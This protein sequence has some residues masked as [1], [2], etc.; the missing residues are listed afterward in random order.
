[1]KLRLYVF[2]AVCCFLIPDHAWAQCAGQIM[3]PGFQFLSSSKGC[4]PF[5]FQIQTKYFQS[6]PGTV[7][8]VDFGDG[9]PEQIY[10]QTTPGPDGPVISHIYPNSPQNC[11]YEL[12]IE[13]ENTCN[14]RGSTPLEP[15]FVTVWT[16]DVLDINPQEFRVCQGYAATVQFTDN[17]TWNCFPHPNANRENDEARWIQWIYGTGAAAT[18]IPGVQINSIAPGA[19]PY[20]DPAPNRNPRYPV[21]APGEVTLPITVPVTA[22]ADIGKEFEVT[23]KNWNQCNPYDATPADGS[24][25]PV[26]LINGDNPAEIATARIVIVDA[27]QPNF[28]AR[29]GN[30][31]G[32]VQTVFCVGDAIFF[33]NETPAIAGAAFAYTWEFFD[34]N[35][36]AGAPIATRTTTNPTFTYTSGGQKLIRLRV[37]D[38]NAA[39]NCEAIF[40][41]VITIS[42]SLIA[43]ISVTDLSG[44]TITPDF[45]QENSAPFTTFNAR[46]NDASTGVATPSTEWRWEFY[47]EA[48]ALIFEAPASG[49]FSNTTL[50]PFDRSFIN[51]GI[52]RVRL[53]VRDNVTLCETTDEVQVRVFRNPVPDFS[54]TRVCEGNATTFT[55]LSTLNPV[56][57]EQIVS[58]EWD[59]NYDGVTFSKDPTL[60]NLTTFTR[61]LSTPGT[62]RVALRVTT[63]QGSCS[64]IIDHLVTVDPLPTANFTAD[65]TSG[66]SVLA[67]NFTNNSIAGQPDTILEYR[68]EIDG[69]SGF[70]VDSIQRPGDPGF[71]STFIRNFANSGGSNAVYQVRLRVV[72]VNGCERVGTPIAITVFPAPRA[73]FVSLNYS[74]FN[75]NCS[76]VSV[77]FSVDAQ[78]QSLNPTDYTWTIQDNST[79]I[80]QTST[81]TNPSFT[82]QFVNTS[83]SIK[84]FQ[85]TLKVDL[86]TGCSG[87]ST[88]AVRISPIPSSAFDTD[89]LVYECERVV[90]NLDAAQKGLQE[91]EWTILSN[92]VTLFGSTTI[93]DNFNYEIFRSTSAD[94]NIEIRLRTTNLANCE[95]SV[96]SQTMFIPRMQ[97]INPSFT[98]LPAA[99]QLPEAT[100]TVTNNTNAGPWQYTWDFGDGETSTT[101]ST[102]PISH[103]YKDPGFYT[104]VL[105]VTSEN[106]VKTQAATIQIIPAKPM[107]DFDYDPASGCAPLTVNFRNLSQYADETTY[108]WQFGVNQGRSQAINPSYTYYE[109]GIYS[110][111][112][113]A[114]NVAGEQAQIV[115]QQIIEVLASPNAQFNVKPRMVQFPDG[116]LYTD[117]ESFG[118]TSYQWN[119]G[120]GTTSTEF[121]PQHV[122]TSEGVFDITL[123]AYNPEGCSD[124]TTLEAGV[125]TI[126]S[127][128]ILVP[129]AFSPNTSGPGNS[130]GQ[131]DTFRPILRGVSEFQMLVFNRWGELLFETTNAEVG[132]DGYYQGKLCQQDVYIYKIIG[133]Y[134]N[135]EKVNK[136]GDIHL[137]R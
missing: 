23:L 10:V 102:T 24:T 92:A 26:D 111:S 73:G 50:G 13:A 110:V 8:Y 47:D 2:I 135:G 78:T 106:C 52:Y 40:D 70:V 30:A 45:C 27:P 44:N 67:V 36:G 83:Q 7:Y 6:T 43:Q 21:T 101:T 94:Q 37:R 108:E 65:Q 130:G 38:T 16:N 14:P 99:Q 20:F 63:D 15:I 100:V 35:T 71:S 127:G 11:F 32:P 25:N 61:T 105:T 109:P 116:K 3:E 122:Y 89:T 9:T 58:R 46:M 12:N 129:N 51:P 134:S 96:N 128:Q 97:V 42:P 55:D 98:A 17:S 131:N 57:S 79:I 56:G 115:K 77:S 90:L 95:S 133:K 19:F 59:L 103:T 80:Q 64:E 93:G 117:N 88:R 5:N 34:N 54:F 132:W 39:G 104:I 126:R 53:R 62:H 68:W 84:D 72:T 87:D 75:D 123:I 60:D 48:N 112:L 74:P 49:A 85:V 113:T 81:G 76:P 124:T 119:F 41:A 31:A 33:D 4:A 18:Q 86:P 69:G 28:I 125:Q 66:C 118:A 107:L 29:L 1:M 91:Y 136:V 22:P 120:D 114:K 121:E 137:I 82:Y